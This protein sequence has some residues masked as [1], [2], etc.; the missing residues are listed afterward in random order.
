VKNRKGAPVLVRDVASVQ[1]GTAL[2]YGATTKDGKGEIVCG[3]A[4][5]LKGENSSA[6]VGRVK[7]KMEQI[8]KTL[9]EGVIAEAFIDR[10]KLVK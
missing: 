8:N 5:M 6:V 4:L 1:E 3:L 10:G 7:E 2:R 9:P